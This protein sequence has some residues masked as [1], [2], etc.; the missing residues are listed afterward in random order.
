MKLV[1]TAAVVL[2]ASFAIAIGCRHGNDFPA[3]SGAPISPKPTYANLPDGGLMLI[4][5]SPGPRGAD[6]SLGFPG[7]TQN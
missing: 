4:P 2:V 1:A 5:D 7:T 6:H 3:S